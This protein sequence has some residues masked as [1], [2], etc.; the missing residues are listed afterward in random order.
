MGA[1]HPSKPNLL[2]EVFSEVSQRLP[3]WILAALPIFKKCLLPLSLCFRSDTMGGPEVV[4]SWHMHMPNFYILLVTEWMSIE[5]WAIQPESS[6]GAFSEVSSLGING[7]ISVF[8]WIDLKPTWSWH[9]R[10]ACTWRWHPR[11]N[12]HEGSKCYSWVDLREGQF[13]MQAVREG[14]LQQGRFK[15]LTCTYSWF[16]L[17]YLISQVVHGPGYHITTWKF[18]MRHIS[19]LFSNPQFLLAR[20]GNSVRGQ[21][22][23]GF[24]SNFLSPIPNQELNPL[25]SC[26]YNRA[27]A[28]VVLQKWG[29]MGWGWLLMYFYTSDFS[30]SSDFISF[31]LLLYII[32]Y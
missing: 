5:I 1:S 31:L 22:H 12:S 10:A 18:I 17:D 29:Q 27:L 30:C 2:K 14:Q 24:A 4:S 16:T 28:N 13:Q 23:C 8:L 15:P 7:L 19:H 3:C 6:R 11:A 26:M 20:I 21:T 25:M 32:V 9:P